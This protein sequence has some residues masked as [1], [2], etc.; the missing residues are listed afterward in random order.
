MKKFKF[1]LETLL[2]ISNLEKEKAELAFSA[3]VQALRRQQ[4][5][6]QKLQ[7][8]LVKGKQDYEKMLLSRR[9]SAGQMQMYGDYFSFKQKQIDLQ[10]VAVR[11]AEKKKAEELQ[12]MLEISKKVKALEQ[13]KAERFLEYKQTLLAEEQKE[14]D[15]IGLQV[16]IHKSM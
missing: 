11:N 9:V 15:E 6:L 4:D 8:E 13:L 14:I 3:A 7:E 1:Q 2:K 5:F 10:Q 12:K 16:Y